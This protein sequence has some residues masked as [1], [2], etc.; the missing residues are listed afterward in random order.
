MRPRVLGTDCGAHPGAA[1]GYRCL[2][3]FRLEFL[4]LRLI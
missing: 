1:G 4:F 3:F 2:F